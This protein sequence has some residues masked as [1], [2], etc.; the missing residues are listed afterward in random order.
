MLRNT[1]LK[2]LARNT[3][4]KFGIEAAYLGEK[5]FQLFFRNEKIEQIFETAAV[6]IQ[7]TRCAAVKFSVCD[8]NVVY[9]RGTRLEEVMENWYIDFL[10]MQI[11]PSVISYEYDGKPF[12]QFL[13]DIK[14]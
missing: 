12:L 2:I 14:M 1:Y 6:F 5:E 8:I 3:A 7:E 13:R 4:E 11:V 10:S 9:R